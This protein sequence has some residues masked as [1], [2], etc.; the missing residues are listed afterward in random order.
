VCTAAIKFKSPLSLVITFDT[1]SLP[2]VNQFGQPIATSHFRD[3]S[4]YAPA[5]SACLTP[6]KLHDP[7]HSLT[8][9]HQVALRALDKAGFQNDTV[10][11]LLLGRTVDC[12][13][14]DLR[15]IAQPGFVEHLA[16]PGLHDYPWCDHCV[17]YG[18]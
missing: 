9:D 2:W 7:I 4:H 10:Q 8:R 1:L 12:R 14:L 13:T 6:L 15:D 18:E 16:S 5:V 3:F 11:A 17:H